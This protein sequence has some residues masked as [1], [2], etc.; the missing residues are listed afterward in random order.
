MENI[1]TQAASGDPMAVAATWAMVVVY[2]RY[3]LTGILAVVPEQQPGTWG[4][5]AVQVAKVL[6]AHVPSK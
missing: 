5:L 4:Y 1:V 3:V 2:G 6:L